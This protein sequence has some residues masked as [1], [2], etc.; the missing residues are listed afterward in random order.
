MLW[1][2]HSH[3]SVLF[4]NTC[5]SYT[6]PSNSDECW[7]HCY[8]CCNRIWLISSYEY[9]QSQSTN[10]NSL[11]CIFNKESAIFLSSILF[12]FFL[13]G[14]SYFHFRNSFNALWNRFVYLVEWLKYCEIATRIRIKSMISFSFNWI[15]I[16]IH[17]QW[18]WKNYQFKLSIMQIQS[19]RW[20][21]DS[22]QINEK[23]FLTFSPSNNAIWILCN[24]ISCRWSMRM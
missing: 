17:L 4:R 11:K 2:R 8:C 13:K 18:N 1:K 23:D 5:N 6:Y 12:F 7:G 9:E 3:R 24:S 15:Y 21:N 10:K 16:K 19:N 20:L 14:N 22:L